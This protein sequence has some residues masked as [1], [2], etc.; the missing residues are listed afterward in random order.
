MSTFEDLGNEV[1]AALEN[2]TAA[3][4]GMLRASRRLLRARARFNE[5]AQPQTLATVHE[6]RSRSA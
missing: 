6:I 3:Q 4:E 1:D 2:F 5:N